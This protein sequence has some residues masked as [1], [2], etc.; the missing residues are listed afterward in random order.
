MQPFIFLFRELI[1]GN[2]T[3]LN[4]ILFIISILIIAVINILGI[5]HVQDAFK[6]GDASKI[7]PIGQI[8][9]QIAPIILFY[10]I[11]LKKSPEIYSLYFLI[12]GMTLVLVAGFLLGRRQGLIETMDQEKDNELIEK[13]EEGK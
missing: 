9:Q 12:F 3:V 2:F 6:H 5:A 13:E 8:P 1:R 10:G 4:I 7:Y 11:Y